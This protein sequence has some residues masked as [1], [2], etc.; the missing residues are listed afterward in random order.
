VR[1]IV[2][3]SASPGRRQ[4]LEQL[5][6]K[7]TIDPSGCHEDLCVEKEPDA[8]GCS[9]SLEKAKKAASRYKDA[10]V[11]AADTFGVFEGRMIGKPRDSN[12]AREILISLSGRCHGVITGFTVMDSKTEKSITR[13]VET[14]VFMRRFSPS[15]IDDYVKTGEPLDKAGAYA[16]QG[17]GAALVE[18]IEG[19]YYNVVGLPLFALCRTLEEFDI[20]IF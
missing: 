10:V 20:K 18:R 9:L 6:L 5:G 13:T 2:L 19:D 7:F 12:E 11:I 4:L 8:R 16:I 3:A 14:Q 15:E 17:L 1:A